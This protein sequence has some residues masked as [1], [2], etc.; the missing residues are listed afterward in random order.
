MVNINTEPISTSS[1]DSTE[2]PLYRWKTAESP[3]CIETVTPI[4]EPLKFCLD[5]S[6]SMDDE[7]EDFYFGDEGDDFEDSDYYSALYGCQMERHRL[8]TAQSEAPMEKSNSSRPLSELL[9]TTLNNT[10]EDVRVSSTPIVSDEGSTH[11]SYASLDS[12]SASTS[13]IHSSTGEL[14]HRD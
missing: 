13:C 6:S 3:L 14:L 11:S 7:D 12:L 10:E 8:T 5:D 4:R 2:Q 9:V 1:K